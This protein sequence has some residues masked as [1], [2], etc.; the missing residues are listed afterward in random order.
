MNFIDPDSRETV[1]EP[2]KQDFRE[3]RAEEEEEVPS[4]MVYILLS[5]QLLGVACITVGFPLQFL[6][7]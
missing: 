3:E 5:T 4:N 6:L 2:A 7:V 1:S